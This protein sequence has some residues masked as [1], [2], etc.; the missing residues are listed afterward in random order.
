MQ[1]EQQYTGEQT[2]IELINRLR[3]L[4]SKYTLLSE[5]LLVV[6]QTM[7]EEYKKLMKEIKD[8]E[9]QI[10]EM[11]SEQ[12]NIALILKHLTEE[13]REFAKTENLKVLEK[14]IN[15]WNP[16]KFVTES[17]VQRIVQEEL[18]N[19]HGRRTTH[20]SSS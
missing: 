8:L 16:L 10:R 14:Y 7:I 20:K 12:K 4:E 17:D 1:V 6:N 15:L 13:A 2:V 3:V 5:K 18:K 19:K 11:R 9:V